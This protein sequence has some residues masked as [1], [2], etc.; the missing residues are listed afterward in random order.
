[1]ANHPSAEKRSRQNEKRRAR[2]AAFRSR[3][4]KAERKLRQFIQSKD[5]TASKEVLP[6]TLSEIMHAVTKGVVHHK[7]A[8]RK[9]S[10][11]SRAVH[12]LS[13]ANS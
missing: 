3:V 13:S 2:N 12:K 5:A 6:K 8:S 7:T 1:M 11:L 10:R 4:H 9:I